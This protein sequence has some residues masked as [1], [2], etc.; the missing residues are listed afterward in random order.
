MSLE[1]LYDHSPVWFQNL[2]C[3][4]K[5]FFICKE[6]YCDGFWN[7]LN[8]YEQRK[9][10]QSES[11]AS[12]LKTIKETPA[13]KHIFLKNNDISGLD[14]LYKF[15][16]IN[17]VDVKSHFND[18]INP[19]CT[20]EMTM[21]STSGT[22]GGGLVFPY[23][24]QMSNKQ[25]AVWWRYRRALGITI[26]TWCGWFGGKRIID[27]NTRKSPFWRINKPG[28]QVMFSSLHLTHDTVQYYHH[29]ID[30][31]GL[32]W[33]HGYPSHIAKFA[34]MAIDKGLPPLTN[35]RFVTTGAE[36][37]LGNQISLFKKMFPNALIRQ[38]YGLA[39]GVANISQNREGE[40]IV[41]DDFSFIEFIPISKENPNVCR[42]IGTN[43]NNPAFPL[44]RYDTGDTATIERHDDGSIKVISIDG[45][46]ANVLKGPD[47]FE[48]NEARLSIVLHDFNN[49]V[50]AQFIQ[51][52]L[53]DIDLLIV[54]NHLYNEKDELLL[55][56]NIK[57]NFDKRI[58][59]TIKYVDSVERTAAGKLR[60]VITEIK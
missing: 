12:F 16:I 31:R 40:W 15:P 51:H 30:K 18:F 55:K 60:L 22:T 13:Y 48:I 5:G 17:K 34:A 56:S 50:E 20:E 57:E 58:K 44:L 11:L 29:E 35:V 28:K 43:F 23:T 10:I 45:R 42:I 53:T 47:G 8:A 21:T 41:D 7:E 39:E 2:M 26:D 46:S 33:L 54:K 3:S 37:V 19:E 52:S 27:P 9:Y 25:W 59:V 6:R 24:K 49:I 32:E 4:I 36:N 38:H 14:L 1:S